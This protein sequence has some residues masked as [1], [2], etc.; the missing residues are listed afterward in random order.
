[1]KKP[2]IRNI[3]PHFVCNSQQDSLSCMI[4]ELHV[5]V[6]EHK[7]NRSNFT[8]EQKLAVID[9]IIK[10]LKVNETKNKQL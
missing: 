5:K 4:A 10:N 9:N 8:T 6:I 2:Q 3:I 1:M 7:L